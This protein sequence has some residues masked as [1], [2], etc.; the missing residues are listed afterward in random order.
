MEGARGA[1]AVSS[2]L[3]LEFTKCRWDND[4]YLGGVCRRVCCQRVAATAA[5]VLYSA[6]GTGR[7]MRERWDGVAAGILVRIAAVV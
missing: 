5:A 6:D 3:T 7:C 1:V 2:S 4:L